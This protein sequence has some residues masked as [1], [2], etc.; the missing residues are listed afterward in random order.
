MREDMHKG[1]F[2]K[3]IIWLRVTYD[4]THNAVENEAHVVLECPLH[5]PI[6]DK[7]LL[8]FEDAILGSLNSYFQYDHEVNINLYLTKVATCPPQV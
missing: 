7:F 1:E 5:N 6:R 4:F 8:I 2:I 3:K